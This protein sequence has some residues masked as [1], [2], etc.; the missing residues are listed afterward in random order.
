[1]SSNHVLREHHI[2][3]TH[4][5]IGGYWSL[6]RHDANAEPR[7]EVSRGLARTKGVRVAIGSRNDLLVQTAKAFCIAMPQD[8]LASDFFLAV[9]HGCDLLHYCMGKA[10]RV[11]VVQ[12]D[13]EI[14]VLMRL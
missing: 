8:D 13:R 14:R 6:I 11:T 7:H 12:H 4:V 10:G 9:I 1:M 5:I 2:H 3:G